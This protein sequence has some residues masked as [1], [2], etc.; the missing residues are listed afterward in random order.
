MAAAGSSKQPTVRA[1]TR[2]TIRYGAK[3]NTASKSHQIEN[4]H[5]RVSDQIRLARDRSKIQKNVV[6][7]R[8][9]LFK[10]AWTSLLATCFTHL[11][12]PENLTG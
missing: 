1:I 7:D 6:L 3:A 10:K 11:Q 2:V 12:I 9:Q 5:S 4:T 8:C